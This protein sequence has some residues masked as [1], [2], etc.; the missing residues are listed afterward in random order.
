VRRALVTGA[1]GFIGRQALG[2]LLDRGFEVHAADVA[3]APAEAPAGVIWHR[4][5]LLDPA[6][7]AGLLEAV[8][9]THLLHL[10]WYA[11]PGKF[12]T[13]PENLS[14]EQ[15]TLGLLRAFD[16]RA[17][18]AGTC[19]EYD[20]SGAESL[21]E[22]S[23]PLRPRSLYGATKQA[24]GAAAAALGHGH[25]RVFFLYGP[26]EHPDRLVASVARAL[27]AGEPAPVSHGEQVR[28]FLHVADVGGA[29]AALLDSDVAGPVNIG[30]GQ[31]VPVRRVVEAIGAETG[32]AELIRWG[33]IPVGPDDPPRI[34]ADVTRLSDEV[35]FAPR[36][37]LED[38]LRDTVSW[39]RERA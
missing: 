4:A 26:G 12:W 14:W 35:G 21:H 5:D 39:W 25:G 29:F 7:P 23:T 34:V 17:V 32:A 15:A 19:A 11:V 1:G 8:A 2:A 31:G 22:A 3:E 38:G 36:F 10:A 37:G 6:G 18:T 28:D 33:E 27:L 30:S 20:W 9:P 24:V 16:G 13:A